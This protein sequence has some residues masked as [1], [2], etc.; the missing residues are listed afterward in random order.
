M[1]SFKDNCV[2]ANGACIAQS[3]NHGQIAAPSWLFPGSAVENA[4]FLNGKVNECELLCFEPEAPPVDELLEVGGLR[5]HVHLPTVLPNGNGGWG[6]AWDA[7][8]ERFSKACIDI[9]RSCSPLRPWGAVLHLP[10]ASVKPFR[11]AQAMLSSFLEQWEYAGLSRADLLPENIHDASHDVF[12]KELDGMDICFDVAHHFSCS[13]DVMPQ[14]AILEKAALLH[15][16]APCGGDAH[17]PLSL[18]TP[19]QTRICKAI[20]K[21]A[22]PDAV[23]CIEVY[24]LQGFWESRDI[25]TG[26]ML[27]ATL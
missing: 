10:N 20:A 6:N 8:V 12:G 24:E 21:L 11:S 4:R 7:G 18:L 5:W 26:F 13:G 1:P 9:Y 23:H 14:K 3:S 17:A 2:H 25:L 16:S 19:C 15:W 27:S 22:R